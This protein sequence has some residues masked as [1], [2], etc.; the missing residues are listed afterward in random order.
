MGEDADPFFMGIS[1]LN[2]SRGTQEICLPR[3]NDLIAFTQ[4]CSSENFIY[5]LE[6]CLEQIQY[7]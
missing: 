2:F 4:D 3:Y 1:A 7:S 6:H 5:I